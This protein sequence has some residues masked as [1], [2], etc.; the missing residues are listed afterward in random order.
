MDPDSGLEIASRPVGKGADAI[1]YDPVRR[2]V[3]ATAGDDGTLTVI[4]VGARKDIKVTQTIAT[5][6]GVR[7]GA[8]DTETGVLYLPA[9]RFD[10]SL[11]PVI[12]PGLPA[13]PA[14][15]ADTFE[16]LVVRGR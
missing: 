14:A 15:V 3:F 5:Q 9:V 8:I 4:A 1:L 16:F 2:V 13:M 7:L 12:L 10:K 11:P 6:P